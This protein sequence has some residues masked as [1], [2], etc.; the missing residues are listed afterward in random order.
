MGDSG[1]AQRGGDAAGTPFGVCVV[2]HAGRVEVSIAGDIDLATRQA[3]E[4]VL[5]TVCS[6]EPYVR[7]DLSEVDFLDPHGAR[8]LARCQATH[9]RLE[10]VAASDCVRRIIA[11]LGQLDGA[12]ASPRLPDGPACDAAAT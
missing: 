1:T 2:T 10:I 3:F 7:L 8:E 5:H 12:G 4:G 11:I 9:P 6:L